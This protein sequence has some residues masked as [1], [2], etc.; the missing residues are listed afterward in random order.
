MDRVLVVMPSYLEDFLYCLVVAQ[1]YLMFGEWKLKR[2]SEVV[3]CC[4]PDFEFLARPVFP[5]ATFC[6]GKEDFDAF[7][8]VLVLDRSRAFRIGSPNKKH[9]VDSYG[10]LCGASPE[11]RLPTVGGTLDEERP[12]IVLVQRSARDFRGKDYTYP[13]KDCLATFRD[14]FKEAEL[15]V[16]DGDT[17]VKDAHR[18]ISSAAFC[19]GV[20]GGFTLLAAAMMK[21]VLELYPEKSLFYREWVAKWAAPFYRVVPAELNEVPPRFLSLT[22]DKFIGEVARERGIAWHSTTLRGS[23]TQLVVDRSIQTV[24]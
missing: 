22:L 1:T 3:V 16:I 15:V 17:P 7:D 6:S 18:E 8:A 14:I 24:R 19:C 9:L 21:P 4:E 11:G 2:K 23:S 20:V 5:S 10:I 12:R 13:F